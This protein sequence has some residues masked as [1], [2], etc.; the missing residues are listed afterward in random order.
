MPEGTLR[1]CRERPPCA[2]R[3]HLLRLVRGPLR[4]SSEEEEEEEEE[5]KSASTADQNRLKVF[6]STSDTPDPT[7]SAQM[8]LA[9][10]CS[11]CP[12]AIT[13][14]MKEQPKTAAIDAVAAPLEAPSQSP[15]ASSSRGD[16]GITGLVYGRVLQLVVP[17]GTTHWDPIPV[18]SHSS[19]TEQCGLSSLG[20]FY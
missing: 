9:S 11:S 18:V 2:L 16:D 17:I 10:D 6:L 8:S 5:S 14:A 20:K 12:W 7:V 3:R 13:S 19:P 1:C 4:S 15:S